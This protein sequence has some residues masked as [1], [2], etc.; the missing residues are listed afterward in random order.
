MS[1]LAGG[2]APPKDLIG[3]IKARL[4]PERAPSEKTMFGETD[5]PGRIVR[6]MV[7]GLDAAGFAIHE[8]G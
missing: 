2:N 5:L 6:G 7:P 3:Q 4:V 8:L 1:I